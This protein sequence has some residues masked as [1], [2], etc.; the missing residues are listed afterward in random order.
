MVTPDPGAIFP[1]R[2]C[3]NGLALYALDRDG[4]GVRWSGNP[5]A[6][7]G[8]AVDDYWWPCLLVP[9]P[10]R[11]AERQ[12]KKLIKQDAEPKGHPDG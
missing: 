10:T 11:R 3:N 1:C 12:R 5:V 8:H 4:V 6:M 2:H 7:I 9:Q